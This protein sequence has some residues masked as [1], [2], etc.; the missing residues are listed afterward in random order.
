MS[1]VSA[2]WLWLLIARVATGA[3]LELNV[4]VFVILPLLTIPSAVLALFDLSVRGLTGL[5]EAVRDLVEEGKLRSRDLRNAV[6][7]DREAPRWKRALHFFR[8]VLELR[9][10]VLRGRGLLIAAGLAVRMRLFNPLFL[11]M[12]FLAFAASVAIMLAA[13]AGTLLAL[14]L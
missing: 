1:F 8:S 6:R 7:Y 10:L 11:A 5:P 13:V 3:W 14:L 9:G 2:V 12:L 4:A